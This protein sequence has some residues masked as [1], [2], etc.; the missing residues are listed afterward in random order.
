LTLA[1]GGVLSG[2]VFDEHGQ[3]MP[4]VPVMPWEVRTALSGERTLDF[5]ATGGESVT[6][7]DRGAYRVY[8]L[9]PGEYTI[10]TA[11]FYSG[12]PSA[13]RVPTDAEIRAAFLAVTQPP[14]LPPAA[15]PPAPPSSPFTY[16]YTRVFLPDSI[17]PLAATTVQLAA[18]DEREGLD[19]HMQLRPMSKIEGVVMG[20]D[21]PPSTFVELMLFR[22]NR[23]QALTST[24]VWSAG[25]DGRFTSVSL[26]PGDYTMRASTKAVGDTPAMWAMTDVSIAGADPVQ[27]TLRLEPAMVLTGRIA[28]EAT[29]QPP[30]ADVSRVR[31]TLLSTAANGVATTGTAVIEP[32][33]AFSISGVMP[34]SFRVAATMPNPAA[35]GRPI[36]TLRSVMSG[37]RDLTD[38][39]IDVGPGSTPSLTVTLTDQV[40]ELSGTLTDA[41]GRPAT[42]YFLVVLPADRKYWAL[43]SRRIVN[44]RP[45]VRGQFVFRALPPGDYRIAA[46]RDLVPRDLTD[47]NAL[48]QLNDRSTAVT[49]APGEKKVFDIAV[50]GR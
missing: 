31:L 5:P 20:P 3:P 15:P 24:M 9:P 36:W 14:S 7:D 8:G 43:S 42:D 50:D 6:T 26:G 44:A 40:S 16:N 4:G 28:F 29:T 11:W 2:T 13:L 49:L 34:G 32:S 35:P 19:L 45:D 30:P 25:R 38:V 41:S 17:D 21:G 18:G 48:S 46:T 33:G 27:V 12:A 10:G 47:A 23:V 1:R 22:R 39:P 37:E